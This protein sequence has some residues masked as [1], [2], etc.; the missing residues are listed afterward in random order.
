MHHPNFVVGLPYLC[1]YIEE[2]STNDEGT[3]SRR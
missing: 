2:A 1:E 3:I